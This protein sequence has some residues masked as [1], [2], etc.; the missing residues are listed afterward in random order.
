MCFLRKH[1][2]LGLAFSE[3]LHFSNKCKT[4]DKKIDYAI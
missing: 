4:N 3:L 1:S 2:M